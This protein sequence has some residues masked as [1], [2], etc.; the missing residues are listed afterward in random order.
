[1]PRAS[2][3]VRSQL[4]IGIDIDFIGNK[5]GR[6]WIRQTERI[7]A[8]L[9]AL[10]KKKRDN[11]PPKP[12][13]TS[14][15]RSVVVF[16]C[17]RPISP[18]TPLSL[19]T[20]LYG[21]SETPSARPPEPLFTPRLSRSTKPSCL[22][23]WLR[24]DSWLSVGLGRSGRRFVGRVSGGIRWLCMWWIFPRTIWWSWCG[25]FALPSDMSTG[26]FGRF[27]LI[28]GGGSLPAFDGGEGGLRLRAE[29]VGIEACAV[30]EGIRLL[31]ADDRGQYSQHHFNHCPGTGMWR[32]EIFC[33]STDKATNR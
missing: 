5:A 31:D 14:E 9:T 22:R 28:V 18:F 25:I 3:E 32:K 7:A 16:E 33:V 6:G 2:C 24:L 12:R 8:M 23:S 11:L 15:L 17:F 20:V 1:M 13:R 10:I 27:A 19:L 4:Y 26:I 21:Y 30:R 29:S